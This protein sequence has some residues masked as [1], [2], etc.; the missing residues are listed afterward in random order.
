MATS[1]ILLLSECGERYATARYWRRV[2]QKRA[3]ASLADP[4]P[5][6][7]PDLQAFYDE[8]SDVIGWISLKDSAINFPVMQTPQDPEYYLYR[9]LEKEPAEAGAPFADYRCHVA[10]VQGFNVVVYAHDIL[11]A[12]LNQYGYR[13]NYFRT[14]N[15]I[16]FDTL[17][18]T[19]LY[20]VAAA[21]YIDASGARLLDPWDPD[22]NQAYEPYNYL[23]VDSLE[24]FQKF[25]DIVRQRQILDNIPQLSPR[26]RILTLICCATELFSGI[27]DNNG[28]FVVIAQRV[29]A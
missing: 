4:N 27:P 5:D 29:G 26:S 25:A 24:G 17:S 16:R 9:N 28:R 7:S 15:R 21:F 13:K 18:E 11:F 20:Q 6:R 8:N 1:A 14:H 2:A 23:E 12:Q 3:D 10:P 19:G 22:D